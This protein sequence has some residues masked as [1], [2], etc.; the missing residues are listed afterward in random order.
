MFLF[1]PEQAAFALY[2]NCKQ[3]YR[4]SKMIYKHEI[5]SSM[6]DSKRQ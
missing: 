5:M 1:I 2:S 6:K 4:L 3:F